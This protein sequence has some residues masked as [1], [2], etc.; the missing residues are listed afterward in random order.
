M[1]M[2]PIYGLNFCLPDGKSPFKDLVGEQLGSVEFV[3]DYVQLHFNGQNLTAYN[4]PELEIDGKI[5]AWQDVDF[6]N[7]LCRCILD[8]V[9][10]VE[11]KLKE[12][13]TIY[14]LKGPIFRIPLDDESYVG[15]EAIQY[16][17]GDLW[18]I[19]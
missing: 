5:L 18:I 2:S 14:F 7:A 6:K 3:A 10:K 1:V 16:T 9:I 12:S 8:K 13:L 11:L 19:Q 4:D 17:H 15:P